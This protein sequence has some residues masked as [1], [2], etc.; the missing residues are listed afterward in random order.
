MSNDQTR[1]QWP[2]IL[3]FH[4]PSGFFQAEHFQN[5][6]LQNNLIHSSVLY[7]NQFENCFFLFRFVADDLMKVGDTANCSF[8][9]KFPN[10]DKR[11]ENVL[12]GNWCNSAWFPYR[13]S[14]SKRWTILVVDEWRVQVKQVP[15]TMF[16]TVTRNETR[17][18]ASKGPTWLNVEVDFK[19]SAGMTLRKPHVAF[20]FYF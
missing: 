18:K 14:D 2:Q 8:D 5:R 17:M 19:F 6:R 10:E 7:Q 1:R 13:M 15:R 20:R 9:C 16:E 4:F 12:S 3:A 11:K